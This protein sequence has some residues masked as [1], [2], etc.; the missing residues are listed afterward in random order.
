MA[1]AT[2]TSLPPS[3]TA[4]TQ[5]NAGFATIGLVLGPRPRSTATHGKSLGAGHHPRNLESAADRFDEQVDDPGAM[6]M[7]ALREK[8]GNATFL[9]TSALPGHVPVRQRGDAPVR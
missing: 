5:R 4:A 7:Q 6:T 9:R 8:V 2:S 3:P 1:L